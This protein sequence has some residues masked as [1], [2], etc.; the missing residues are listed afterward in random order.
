MSLSAAARR[1]PRVLVID[2]DSLV[3]RTLAHFL[4]EK[5]YAH[6]AAEDGTIGLEL[7]QRERP[8]VVVLDN[9]LPGFGGIE[10][11]KRIR[12]LDRHLPVL[13]VTSQG[14]SRNAIEA[15]KLC[16]FDYLPK[17]LDLSR[18]E[19]QLDRALEARRLMRTPVQVDDGSG[20]GRDVDL[21][22]GRS[23]AMQEVYKAIGRV[24][25]LDAPILIEGESGTGKESVA[26]AVYQNGTRADRP[27]RIVN[28]SDFEGSELEVELFGS[29]EATGEAT[30]TSPVGRVER[31]GRVEQCLSG[32]LVLHEIG[33]LTSSAQSRLL[34]LLRD[35]EFERVGGRTAIAADLQVIALTSQEL[36]QLVDQKRFRTDLYYLLRAFR[37]ELPSLRHRADDV[38]LLV[39]HFVKQFSRLRGSLSAEPVRV[40]AE[41]LALL[42]RYSWPGNLDELQSVL[43]R[44]L[45][46]TKGT[47]VASDFLSAA[48]GD[49]GASLRSPTSSAAEAHVT[50]W[51][52]LAE[53]R[54]AG[55]SRS[56]Y[57][58][59]L[60]EMERSL[61]SQVLDAMKGNQARS[62]RILGITRG[63]LRKK[64]RSL[65]LAT[66]TPK[67][68]GDMPRG[69]RAT[70]PPKPEPADSPNVVHDAPLP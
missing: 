67:P 22:I 19:Q 34:R 1:A 16:A 47:I 26:R 17:P 10:V 6:F 68:V 56:L 58:E 15:M 64:L 59:A 49:Q 65:G 51:R 23:P 2:D 37:I 40:S 41:S 70:K 42:K 57:A 35:K 39:D 36:E 11:L 31:V 44:A 38:P 50:D 30:A 62:A 28:C 33:R 61:L 48:I 32:T 9:V 8:D 5:G 13:F 7:V 14:T 43:R 25:L 60:A 3:R 53:G 55:G 52:A 66:A 69:E 12:E 46:E 27:L 4:A 20:D 18:L 54:I 29:E 45:V 24:A 21:L 63:N